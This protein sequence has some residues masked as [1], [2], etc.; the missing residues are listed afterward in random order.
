M[1]LIGNRKR[2]GCAVPGG[3]LPFYAVAHTNV[4]TRLLAVRIRVIDR[5]AGTGAANGGDELEQAMNSSTAQR[6]A[7]AYPFRLPGCT[8]I[9]TSL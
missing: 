2:R 1:L 7:A 8:G 9:N 6:M 4:R 5:C 3:D